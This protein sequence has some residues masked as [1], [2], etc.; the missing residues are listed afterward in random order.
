MKTLLYVNTQTRQ[1]VAWTDAYTEEA[2]QPQPDGLDRIEVDHF[3]IP[4]GEIGDGEELA[5]F[6]EDGTITFTV[7]KRQIS[8]EQKVNELL[9]KWKANPMLILQLVENLAVTQKAL[10]ELILGGEP[11]WSPIS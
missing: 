6:Y 2:L 4:N 10:D 7:Q 8:T 3:Q 11:V 9:D 1:V 5:L